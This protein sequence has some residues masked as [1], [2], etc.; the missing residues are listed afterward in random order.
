MKS[1]QLIRTQQTNT[2]NPT[3]IQQK[4]LAFDEKEN[5]EPKNHETLSFEVQQEEMM[6][7]PGN[8]PVGFRSNGNSKLFAN[9]PNTSNTSGENN[10][11]RID[12]AKIKSLKEKMKTKIKKVC[13]L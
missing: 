8:P 9:I 5:V 6:P 4:S 1:N 13:I 10:S 2:K 11:V 12:K 7:P 3:L